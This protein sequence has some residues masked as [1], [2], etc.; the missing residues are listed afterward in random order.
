MEEYVTGK[1]TKWCDE[2]K[3]LATIAQT[4][5][6]TA[7]SGYTHGLSSR[8]TFLSR[9]IPNIADLLQPLEDAIQHH[10]I[11]VAHPAQE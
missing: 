6:H 11:P 2:I 1:V 8:W 3:Q 5:P 7:Y 10:L 9:T 4:Q